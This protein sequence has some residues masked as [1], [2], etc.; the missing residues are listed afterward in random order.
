MS[1]GRP[2][3]AQTCG[4]RAGERSYP[5]GRLAAVRFEPM[6]LVTDQQTRRPAFDGLRQWVTPDRLVVDDHDPSVEA[7][8]RLRLG[9]GAVMVEHQHRGRTIAQELDRFTFPDWQYSLGC[10][11]Q[12]PLRPQV[13]HDRQCRTS[14]ARPHLPCQ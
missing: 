3:Q 7:G 5:A 12:H 9:F 13:Q 1:E 11:H 6:H 8:E 2:R 14:L 10:Q 4:Y